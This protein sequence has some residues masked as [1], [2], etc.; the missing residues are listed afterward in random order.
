M[1]ECILVLYCVFLVK[2]IKVEV[3]AWISGLK[4]ENFLGTHACLNSL[5]MIFPSCQP[6]GNR[7]VH[8]W[9]LWHESD[10]SL[11]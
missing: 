4:T 11:H 1:G 7:I 8:M 5:P 6:L 9:G 3:Y 10:H 2:G